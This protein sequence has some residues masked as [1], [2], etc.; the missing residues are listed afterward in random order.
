MTR[1][2]LALFA[3]IAALAGF[4]SAAAQAPAARVRL[5]EHESFTRLVVENPESRTYFHSHAGRTVEIRIVGGVISYDLSAVRAVVGNGRIAAVRAGDRGSASLITITLACD[6]EAN[7]FDF[8]GDRIVLD[9]F[10]ARE[11]TTPSSAPA[12]DRAQAGSNAPH[13][14]K[15]HDANA[16]PDGAHGAQAAASGPSETN[17]EDEY[18]TARRRLLAL[19]AQ[20][21]NDGFVTLDEE[22]AREEFHDAQ[23]TGPAPVNES[24]RVASTD[25]E[26]LA[27]PD[28]APSNT[29]LADGVFNDGAV[30]DGDAGLSR[31]ALLRQQLVGEFDTP[32][33]RAAFSLARQY[34]H[35]GFGAEAAN[36]LESLGFDDTAALALIEAGRLLEEKKPAE[37]S[38]LLR[39][40]YCRGFH[41]IWK[42]AALAARD[43]P[44]EALASA[45]RADEAVERLSKPLLAEISLSLGEAAARLGDTEE[46]RLYLALA[47]RAG[48]YDAP[49]P[50]LLSALILQAEGDYERAD[51]ILRQ[52]TETEDYIRAPALLARA[53]LHLAA[54][55]MPD[56]ELLLDLASLA[57]ERRRTEFG[58]MVQR[59]RIELLAESGDVAGAVFVLNTDFTPVYG[60]HPDVVD[61]LRE[62]INKRIKSTHAPTRLATLEAFLANPDLIGADALADDI[63]LAVADAL[64]DTGLSNAAA[65]VLTEVSDARARDR[66]L[67]AAT[68]AYRRA[69]FAEAVSDASAFA[70]EPQFKAL[71]A[72]AHLANGD[73]AAAA[74]VFSD[75]DDESAPL[76]LSALWRLGRW[77]RA[78]DLLQTNYERLSET[79]RGEPLTAAKRLAL[80]AYMARRRELPAEAAAT[81]AAAN[82]ELYQ[83][84]QSFF[85]QMDAP[86]S[87]TLD[88]AKDLAA[89]TARELVVF[90]ELAT[91]G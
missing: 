18:E 32:D 60:E 86:S 83:G 78:T 44:E 24:V 81:L 75:V 67:L 64:I 49:R 82:P 54:G 46:A 45:R 27:R 8:G 72:R 58:E 16:A 48:G 39:G 34:L 89:T 43:E 2:A 3:T 70:D 10:E 22:A 37:N 91:D 28:R 47:E 42:A 40:D 57:F 14:D 6:C 56:E 61:T 31:I 21:A 66:A 19:L 38:A 84:L 17:D 1:A 36:V 73:A 5:G 88:A 53:R 35:L 71:I 59:G 85:T 63:R 20:A 25:G 4:A 65:D 30:L 87:P 79:E 12:A 90:E 50:R 26:I 15:G 13:S 74:D 51:Y 76:V 9:V 11:A 77:D 41:A 55:T 52:L 62:T 69:R 68:A 23:G 80:A 29:C 33:R 7:V